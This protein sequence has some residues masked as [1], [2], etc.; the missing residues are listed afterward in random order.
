MGSNHRDFFQREAYCRYMKNLCCV[1]FVGHAP[2]LCMAE[3]CD[4]ASQ[5]FNSPI[6]FRNEAVPWTV[7]L[8]RVRPTFLFSY[9]FGHHTSIATY[10]VHSSLSD[11]W[12]NLKLLGPT[13]VTRTALFKLDSFCIQSAASNS[14]IS[15][16]FWWRHWESNPKSTA[17]EA[18]VLPLNYVPKRWRYGIR[19]HISLQG[20]R[21]NH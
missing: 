1:C 11:Y 8:P 12:Q 10:L 14:R 2:I 15:I 3:G 9:D 17:C 7:N 19:T 16:R 18:I 13:S 5:R 4:P 6:R 21:S 20:G